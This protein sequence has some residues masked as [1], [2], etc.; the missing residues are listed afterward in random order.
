[1]CVLLDPLRLYDYLITKQMPQVSARELEAQASPLD[2]QL[3]PRSHSFRGSLVIAIE[4]CLDN[5]RTR[6][7]FLEQSDVP[8]F[9]ALMSS[10]LQ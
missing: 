1:M 6:L 7:D 4:L 10:S 9:S 8:V 3:K 5:S 2:P